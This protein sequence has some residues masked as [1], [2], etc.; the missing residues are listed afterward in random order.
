[1]YR[2]W[3]FR[4][5]LAL[6]TPLCIVVDILDEFVFQ[7]CTGIGIQGPFAG[8]DDIEN[9]LRSLSDGQYLGGFDIEALIYENTADGRE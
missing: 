4:K 6:H 3:E 7:Q 5:S 1:M 2:N 8:V 9:V